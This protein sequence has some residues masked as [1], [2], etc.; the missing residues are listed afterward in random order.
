MSI[1][2]TAFSI[3]TLEYLIQVLAGQRNVT[4]DTISAEVN[5]RLQQ[6]IAN[7]E[8]DLK[9]KVPQP[10]LFNYRKY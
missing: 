3:T 7:V 10:E 9:N 4:V 2:S 6:N 5:Q 1:T 8:R